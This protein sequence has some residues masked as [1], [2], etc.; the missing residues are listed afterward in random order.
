[1]KLTQ[2]LEIN[3]Q[4]NSPESLKD[5]FGDGYLLQ[6]N[7][8]YSEIRRRVLDLNFTFSSERDDLYGALPLAQLDR[9]LS[10]KKIPYT[11]N[12]TA[13]EE[14]CRLHPQTTWLDIQAQ[15]KK[16]YLFHESCHAVARSFAPIDSLN[17]EEEKILV[18]LLEE[19]FANSCELLAVMDVHD[20]THRDFF[21]MV[22]YILMFDAKSD[23]QRLAKEIGR[24]GLMRWMMLAYLLSNSLREE[25]SEKNFE[26]MIRI[27]FQEKADQI[28]SAQRKSLRA[29]AKIAFQLNPEFREV[30][31][32]FYLKLAGFKDP[33]AT[34][35]GTDFL[36]LLEGNSEILRF[37]YLI[38]ETIA[39][40][41][42][43]KD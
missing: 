35:Q 11:N 7:S 2:L 25:V 29:M 27:A 14:V 34:I 26:C 1:M 8:I 6:H 9:V 37:F 33:L 4:E 18:R 19:S 32:N 5:H 24:E 39:R 20:K 40:E 17:S 21:E 30:T 12:V 36:S 41:N 10:Q 42:K 31:T 3:K 38:N 15:F 23:L 22:S 43:P 28:F 16:N 13:I